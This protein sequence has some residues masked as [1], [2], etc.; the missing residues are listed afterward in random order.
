MTTNLGIIHHVTTE[1][2]QN[3]YK[4][5]KYVQRVSYI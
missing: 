4:R 3:K 5:N 2:K 1:T